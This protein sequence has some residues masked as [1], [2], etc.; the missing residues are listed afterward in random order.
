MIEFFFPVFVGLTGSLH[1]LGMCGPL[2]LAY[3]LNLATPT[4]PGR[5]IVSTGT[6]HHLAFHMGRVTTYGILGVTVALIAGTAGFAPYFKGARSILTLTAGLAMFFLGIMLLR[7]PRI[8]LFS[9][10][11]S[12]PGV[13]TFRLIN[14][15]SIG[16]K[17]L[18]G[19]SVGFLPCM[20]PWAM[21]MKASAAQNVFH[22]FLTMV[23][24]G[25]GTIPILFFTGF[26][27]SLLSFRLRLLGERLAAVS[28]IIMGVLLIFK[29]LKFCL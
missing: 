6:I 28:V 2:V 16:S 20:L 3:S 13:H 18:L 14:S 11:L 19:I 5:R 23:L 29:G 9:L 27:T 8:K 21:L 7:I 17:Y 15:R 25:L 22:G 10:S 12:G 24:F 1:C 4:G 26:F